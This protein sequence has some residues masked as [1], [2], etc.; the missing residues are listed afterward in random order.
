MP[1]VLIETP[2]E[3]DL[4]SSLPVDELRESLDKAVEINPESEIHFYKDTDL[5][6]AAAA[7][8]VEAFKHGETVQSHTITGVAA[9]DFDIAQLSDQA[10]D[11]PSYSDGEGIEARLEFAPWLD[12]QG[13]IKFH[14]SDRLA[15]KLT[16]ED[17]SRLT[18]LLTNF[19]SV[20][21]ADRK[22]NNLGYTLHNGQTEVITANL[23]IG[24]YDRGDEVN[25][26]TDPSSTR[27]LVKYVA[28]Y[29]VG[30]T[31]TKAGEVQKNLPNN[32]GAFMSERDLMASGAERIPE[33]TVG[34][35]VHDRDVH[36][37]PS[38]KGLR[39]FMDSVVL[40]PS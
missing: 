19:I 6:T 24:A 11:L 9:I 39:I 16:A 15:Q 18:G 28:A 23:L 21:S 34:R 33:G 10:N 22:A 2:H 36:F 35:F 1:D 7:R 20:V 30:G 17:L 40:L 27:P 3:D 4:S 14:L 25:A 32:Y 5:D 26:H 31:G 13:E 38:G 29:G 12:D 8:D 37:A